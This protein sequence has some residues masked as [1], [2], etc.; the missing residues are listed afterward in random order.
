MLC[1]IQDILK[2]VWVGRSLAFTDAPTS[3][4]ITAFLMRKWQRWEVLTDICKRFI[5]VFERFG[6]KANGFPAIWH[7][8]GSAPQSFFLLLA[9]KMAILTCFDM[10]GVIVRR[11]SLHFRRSCNTS[12]WSKITKVNVLF[13]F[14]LRKNQQT[15]A[16]TCVNNC[17][18][19]IW[20][21]SF[22][23]LRTGMPHPFCCLWF[24]IVFGHAWTSD[25]SPFLCLRG[26][27]IS[28]F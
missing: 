22:G 11:D 24:L 9:P 7:Q 28:Q 27:L 20:L 6:G 23:W 4:C 8:T 21:D 2:G 13:P 10:C 14:M 18:R 3:D 16:M 17:S 25:T 1:N 12:G 5:E 19:R 15:L 26:W